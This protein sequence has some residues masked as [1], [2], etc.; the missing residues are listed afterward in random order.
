MSR[1]RDV[2]SR[3]DAKVDSRGPEYTVGHERDAKSCLVRELAQEHRITAIGVKRVLSA[4]TWNVARGGFHDLEHC[5]TSPG[6]D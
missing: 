1:V 5:F 4:K 2:T 3:A 6:E